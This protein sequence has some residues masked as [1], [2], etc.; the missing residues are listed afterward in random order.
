MEGFI[1]EAESR[2]IEGFLAKENNSGK[3]SFRG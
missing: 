2:E 1:E 3:Q